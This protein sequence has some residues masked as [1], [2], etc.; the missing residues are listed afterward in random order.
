MDF[1]TAQLSVD[2]LQNKTL[3]HFHL[4]GY[5]TTGESNKEHTLV[6]IC[7]AEYINYKSSVSSQW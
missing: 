2:F 1:R 5:N 3:N 7:K 6:Q 4:R